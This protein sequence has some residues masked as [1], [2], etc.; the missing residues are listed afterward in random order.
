MG[1]FRRNDSQSNTYNFGW[2]EHPNLT[3]G[4]QEPKPTNTSS[5]SSSSH[6]TYLE[7]IISKLALSSNSLKI[8][9]E[10]NLVKLSEQT[11]NSTKAMK[12][13]I[14]IMKASISEL[15]DKLNQLA[16]HVIKMEEKDKLLAQPNHANNVDSNAKEEKKVKT[17]PSFSNA[18]SSNNDSKNI[19]DNPLPHF[20]SRLSQPR[21]EFKNDEELLEVFKKVEV[22][23][24]LLTAIKSIPR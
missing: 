15:G 9:F 16:T 2:R 14:E 21:K 5:S 18:S 11:V 24:P 13:D 4:S 7:E 19:V 1:G 3:W 20:P 23:L 8:D 17:N 12:N 6:G 10:K 22:N